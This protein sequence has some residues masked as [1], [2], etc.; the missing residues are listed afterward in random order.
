MFFDL[1]DLSHQMT[2]LTVHF[3]SKF[4]LKRSWQTFFIV[5]CYIF[6][7]SRKTFCKIKQLSYTNF[8][9]HLVTWS[10]WSMALKKINWIVIENSFKNILYPHL[11][12]YNFS[13]MLLW[14][15]HKLAS[16]FLKWR[17]SCW[18]IYLSEFH[19]PNV[20][21][22]LLLHGA[23]YGIRRTIR[24]CKRIERNSRSHFLA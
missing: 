11:I 6:Q 23:A 16:A 2:P 3:F 14:L 13:I 22:D 8:Y 1:F 19:N 21:D 9:R 10:G 15:I 20:M 24:S 7:I 5:F 17:R 4:S 12:E 18:Q